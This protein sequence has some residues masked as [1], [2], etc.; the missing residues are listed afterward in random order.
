MTHDFQI[1]YKN[2]VNV[3][4]LQRSIL[5]APV[6]PAASEEGLGM[7]SHYEAPSPTQVADVFGDEPYQQGKLDLWRGYV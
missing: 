2:T 7:C 5:L 4:L 6:R 1:L 3:T